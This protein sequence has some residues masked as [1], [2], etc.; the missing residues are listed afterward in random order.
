[1]S[2]THPIT[3]HIQADFGD[4]MTTSALKAYTSIDARKALMRLFAPRGVGIRAP[5]DVSHSLGSMLEAVQG[6]G[7]VLRLNGQPAVLTHALGHV[8]AYSLRSNPKSP[9]ILPAKVFAKER[10]GTKWMCTYEHGGLYTANEAIV[11]DAGEYVANPL[12]KD[13]PVQFESMY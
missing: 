10:C 2:P 9:V 8:K 5:A 1:M 13:V 6:G 11:T 3:L 7:T 12:M 4:T